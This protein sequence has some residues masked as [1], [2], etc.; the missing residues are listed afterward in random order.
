LRKILFLSAASSVDP[1]HSTL[2]P[3]EQ[4]MPILTIQAIRENPWNVLKYELP[5]EDCPLLFEVAW[6]AADYCRKS[7]SR[8]TN[9]VRRGDYVPPEWQPRAH[10]CDAHEIPEGDA[11]AAE[12]RLREILDRCDDE[13]LEVIDRMRGAS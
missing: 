1:L 4:P 9:A 6:L 12:A 8:L 10:G 7:A 13:T 3:E 11:L 2:T 5:R